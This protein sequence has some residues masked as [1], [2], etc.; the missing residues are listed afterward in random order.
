MKPVLSSSNS[1]WVTIFRNVHGLGV[2]L[3][4]RTGLTG[5]DPAIAIAA[6]DQVGLQSC[7]HVFQ[8]MRFGHLVI[9]RSC[10]VHK[11]ILISCQNTGDAFPPHVSG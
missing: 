8:G 2:G 4:V 1:F 11:D 9:E 6:M 3:F 10:F 7:A 5:L